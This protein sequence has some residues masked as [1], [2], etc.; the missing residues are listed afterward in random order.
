MLYWN[1]EQQ[2]RDQQEG[3]L[4]EVYTLKTIVLRIGPGHENYQNLM[5]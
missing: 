5:V 1:E 3:H 2:K 4:Q